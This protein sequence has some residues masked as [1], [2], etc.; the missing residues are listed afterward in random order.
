M[1]KM[2]I[3]LLMTVLMSVGAVAHAALT[4][5][6]NGTV[7]DS[8][9]GLIWEQGEPGA[10][11]WG[12]ALSYCEGRNLGGS[13]SWRLP[14]IKEL[15][16]LTDDTRWNPSIDTSKFPNAYAS[17]YWSSTSFAGNPGSAWYV[18]FDL[19]YVNAANKNSAFYVRCV[20]GGQSAE[21][22]ILDILWQEATAGWLY[23]W[24]MDGVTRVGGN[25]LSQNRIESTWRMVGIADFNND[26]K[27]DILWQE[28]TAGWLYVWYMNGT[29]KIGGSYLSQNRIEPTWRMVGI[30]DFDGNGK[31]DIL[32]QES[33]AGWLY[34][35]YMDGVTKIGGSYLSQNR[36]DPTWR[37]VGIADFDGNGKS[38]IL[39]QESS[40]GWLYVWYM[41]GVT[42]LGG[43]YLSPNKINPTWRMVGVRDFDGNGKPDIL[44][45]ET[46]AGWLY[47]WYMNGVIKT[48]G[49]YLSP[50][51][52]NPTWR[53]VG[54]GLLD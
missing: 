20:R 27:K 19:G 28:S 16:S 49:S 24:Y 23:V 31:Q 34:V 5:N 45:Q 32:W 52:I 13:T 37:M 14:N 15:E 54:I 46:S 39:W 12:A 1:R 10:M 44:W 50:N 11:T 17:Y 47:V 41:D 43:S 8:R 29:T 35:W 40:A 22:P 26:G 48:G 53:M 4:D 21:G 6:G 2:T 9:T 25:Y 7:T 38:D 36:I 51:Q 3:L 18:D 42:K 33:T 30:A